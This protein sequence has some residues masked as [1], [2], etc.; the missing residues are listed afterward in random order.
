MKASKL[1]KENHFY[2]GQNAFVVGCAIFLLLPR[3]NWSLNRLVPVQARGPNSRPSIAIASSKIFD[4][5]SF[6]MTNRGR[7]S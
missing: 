3:F 4:F 2:S 6:F 1:F 5:G 7:L